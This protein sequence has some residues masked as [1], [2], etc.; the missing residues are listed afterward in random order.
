MGFPESSVT[1]I[2]GHVLC[3]DLGRCAQGPV[4]RDTGTWS[5]FRLLSQILPA[6]ASVA[7]FPGTSGGQGQVELLDCTEN[8]SCWRHCPLAH[9]FLSR[10]AKLSKLV[11]HMAHGGLVGA[12]CLLEFKA[13]KGGWDRMGS[14]M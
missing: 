9:C 2:T 4:T 5:S 12:K 13:T 6:L 14:R 3:Q 11:P 7:L 1:L 10:S 8:S